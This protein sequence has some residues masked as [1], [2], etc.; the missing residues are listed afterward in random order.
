VKFRRPLNLPKALQSC[1]KLQLHKFA[2]FQ[3]LC[4][5]NRLTSYVQRLC[6]LRVTYR[7]SSTSEWKLA[8]FVLYEL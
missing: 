4:Q 7:Q 3:P 8:T 2:N 5:V 6:C 1:G